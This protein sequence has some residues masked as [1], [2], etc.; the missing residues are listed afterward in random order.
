[1]R[2]HLLVVLLLA[3]PSLVSAEAAGGRAALPSDGYRGGASPHLGMLARRSGMIFSGTV[4]RVQHLNPDP[5]TTVATTQITFRVQT[6]IRGV[7]PGQGITVREWVGLWNNGERYRLGERV[8]LFLYPE[9][10]LGTDQSGGWTDGEVSSRQRRA[11]G[12]AGRGWKRQTAET[13]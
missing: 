4:V 11:G 5:S 8:L 1:V 6:A 10:R 13:D 2:I 7:R 12:S 3:L 9:S